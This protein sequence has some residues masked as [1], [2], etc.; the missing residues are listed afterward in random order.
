MKCLYRIVSLPKHFFITF[1]ACMDAR[2]PIL[3]IRAFP[4]SAE[5]GYCQDAGQLFSAGYFTV[6][7]RCCNLHA[8][9]SKTTQGDFRID[10][11]W[12]DRSDQSPLSM[13]GLWPE[14]Q[15]RDGFLQLAI[16]QGAF[17][18]R[19][20]N[21]DGHPAYPFAVADLKRAGQLGRRC[22][23]RR[24]PYMNNSRAGSP[25]HQEAR[26][27]QP[28]FRCVD[29]ALNTIAGY[30]VMNLIRKG[31]IRWLPKTDFVGQVRFIERPLNHPVPAPRSC[32]QRGLGTV[33]FKPQYAGPEG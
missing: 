7:K 31:Q 10:K 9:R 17:K 21:V 20:I 13:L 2:V 27:C 18:P 16:A 26:H 11:Q 22:R 4:Y 6:L 8:I 29:A 12:R 32:A 30:Q 14:N 19:L 33:T 23:W 28:W 1:R 3:K 25:L 24:A 15:A 5:P